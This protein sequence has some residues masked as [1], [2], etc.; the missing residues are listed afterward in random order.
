M[1]IPTETETA[2]W[3]KIPAW[4]FDHEQLDADGIAVLS[5]LSTFADRQGRCWPSQTTLAT[6][7]KRSR[8][9][10]NK[11]VAQLAEIGLIEVKDRWSQSGGRLSSLYTLAMDHESA[12]TIASDTPPVTNTLVT[13]ADI[14]CSA[15]RQ[16][17]LN[18]KQIP[19]SLAKRERKPMQEV[20]GD[21]MPGSDDIAWAQSRFTEIDLTRHVEG[22][23]LR[24]QAHGYRYRGIGAAWRAWLM[25]DV[26]AG[27]APVAQVTAMKA[28][29][30]KAAAMTAKRSPDRSMQ[31]PHETA[32][33]QRLGAWMAVAAR[34]QATTQT[35][36]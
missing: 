21:W 17:H 23:I 15:E 28:M 4:W 3:G 12:E 19:D 18:P 26:A 14:P 25:Q 7:L 22:F 33:E 6:K 27:K 29:P 35:P 36:S 5:A 24:C 31:R 2:R 1:A 10:V 9:W 20:P 30:A 32:A 11:V 16:E 34:L 13:E 8:A